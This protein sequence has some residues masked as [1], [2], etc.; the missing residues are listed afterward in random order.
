MGMTNH[1][2]GMFLATRELLLAWRDRPK[3]EF[4][5]IRQRPGTPSQPA[6]GTQRVWMSSHMLHSKR[7]CDVRQ[8]LPLDGFG[9]LT[10][11]HLPNKNYRRVGHKGR[12]GGYEREDAEDV[13]FAD[14][15]ERFEGPN[16]SLLTAITTARTDPRSE[17]R[18]V[19]IP[20]T[21]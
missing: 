8:V 19:V 18:A 4:D 17:E 15:S 13:Q 10:V 5:R 14:G 12:L 7:F 21:H 11:H 3:C 6:A 20:S 16:S 9:A 2:Q 1:H